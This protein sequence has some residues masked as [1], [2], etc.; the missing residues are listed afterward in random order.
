MR[1]NTI[2]LLAASAM[3]AIAQS[4]NHPDCIEKCIDEN[5]TSS[6]CDGDETGSVKDKCLCDT[7]SGS[8]MIPCMRDCSTSDQSSFAAIVP[9]S[10]RAALFPGVAVDEAASTS[11]A[12]ATSAAQT[13]TST[14]GN[15]ASQ[16]SE[17]AAGAT[18]TDG[19]SAA[20]A[21]EVSALLAVAG[22]MAALLA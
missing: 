16:T 17:A 4:R 21:K 9:E 15:S 11:G 6:F 1:V 10:C 14:S 3:T 20:A 5:P 8:S 2:L 7:Y 19:G 12:A 18:T 22:F 13:A